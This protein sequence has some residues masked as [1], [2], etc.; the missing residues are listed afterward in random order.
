VISKN[1]LARRLWV[2][3]RGLLSLHRAQAQFQ[4]NLSNWSKGGPRPRGWT[5]T[6]PY[7]ETPECRLVWVRR[8]LLEVVDCFAK[9][10][11]DIARWHLGFLETYL[12][13]GDLHRT[14]YWSEYL[15]PRCSPEVAEKR[16]A[17]FVALYESIASSGCH[18]GTHIW[19][20]DLATAPGLESHFG[21]RY[22]RFD[23]SHRLACLH[24]LGVKTVPCLVFS[25][26]CSSKS[27][28][29]LHRRTPPE[30]RGA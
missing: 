15:L 17:R 3:A 21:F 13:G 28:A 2:V 19:V 9:N 26:R 22:F 24:M 8:Q 14:A 4:E 7:I 1:G 30:P 5:R 6:G 23:G 29:A 18:P 25:V 16:C 11:A 20:A 12:S 10:P 27:T